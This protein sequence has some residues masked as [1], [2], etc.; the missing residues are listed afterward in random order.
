MLLKELF[1]QDSLRELQAIVKSR[2]K[3]SVKSFSEKERHIISGDIL[4]IVKKYPEAKK[5]W[6]TGS[7]VFGGH[8]LPGDDEHYLRLR[9]SFRLKNKISDRDYMTSPPIVGQIGE[10][11][12][13]NITK[14]KKIL[15]FNNGLNLIE[16]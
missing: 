6:I 14:S 4:T 12:L 7:Y 13:I 11:D 9:D 1:K 8:I 16:K 15:V 5:I 10:I 3:T 2:M